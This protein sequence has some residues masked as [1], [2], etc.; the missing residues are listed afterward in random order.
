MFIPI[1]SADRLETVN[2]RE[3]P[4]DD[5]EW[6]TWKCA[7]LTGALCAILL[8]LPF[9]KYPIAVFA[10]WV[11]LILI[12][13]GL[14]KFFG[15]GFVIHGAIIVL[16]LSILFLALSP[17]LFSWYDVQEVSSED[18][19]RRNVIQPGEPVGDE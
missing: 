18:I 8:L 14:V 10:V 5:S 1:E 13:L 19:N 12:Y 6:P 2:E 15:S 9:L 17:R 11:T 7:A 4:S 16:I 3:G